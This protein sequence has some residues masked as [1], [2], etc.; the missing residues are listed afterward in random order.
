MLYFKMKTLLIALFFSIFIITFS[1]AQYPRHGILPKYANG[2][3]YKDITI[4]KLRKIADSLNNQFKQIKNIP[5]FISCPYTQAQYIKTDAKKVENR[6]E[7]FTDKTPFEEL[8]KKY[9]VLEINRNAWMYKEASVKEH[10][11]ADFM[12]Y[13]SKSW[14]QYPTD[15]WA[16]IETGNWSVHR[17]GMVYRPF[18]DYEALEMEAS[19]SSS[20]LIQKEIPEKYAKM[21]QYADFL[22][23]EKSNIP[24]SADKK[25]I[26]KK[27]LDLKA[28]TYKKDTITNP[29]SSFFAF[30]REYPNRP[31]IDSC[32]KIKFGDE[33]Y[34]DSIPY[35]KK[36]EECCVKY[37]QNLE[38]WDSL[39]IENIRQSISK[40]D[41]FKTLL[42]E[43]IEETI[44]TGISNPTIEFYIAEFKSKE[45]ALEMSLNRK[46]VSRFA[47]DNFSTEHC[48][49]TKQILQLAAETA[50]WS[51]FI[52]NHLSVLN[53]NFEPE[54]SHIKKGEAKRTYTKELEEIGINTLEF[55]LGSCLRVNNPS[56][57]HHWLNARTVSRAL[58][59]MKDKDKVENIL[60]SLIQDQELDDLNRM[61]ICSVFKNYNCFLKDLER[62]NINEKMY[63]KKL[64]TLPGI[65][66]ENLNK[67]DAPELGHYWFD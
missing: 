38:I 8:I 16:L 17:E 39:R 32:Y 15:K 23:G 46:N 6:R 42:N 43:A 24:F 27:A 20:P 1:L 40:T 2:L 33:V 54:C 58:S 10:H 37:Y 13:I 49:H 48:D 59:E 22:V 52:D 67:F 12:G 64:S 9:P 56:K 61:I 14:H 57:N 44:S 18:Q 29:I 45:L 26:L 51:I 25:G 53:D 63:F 21:I 19:Y 62:Q 3:I 30:V 28:D 5:S 47:F 7:I 34:H 4:Q 11:K 31:T 41:I 66:G 65:L 36:K 60:L 35:S 55:L 50:N